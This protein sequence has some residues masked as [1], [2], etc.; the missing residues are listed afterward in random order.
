MSMSGGRSPQF[1]AGP[2]C[3]EEKLRSA[4]HMFSYY[5]YVYKG[6]LLLSLA[7]KSIDHDYLVFLFNRVA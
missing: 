2:Q 6:A 7:Y 5:F 1:S 4:N 3:L